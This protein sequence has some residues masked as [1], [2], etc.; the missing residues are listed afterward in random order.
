MITL[1]LRKTRLYFY[2]ATISLTLLGRVLEG[3][4][5]EAES[6]RGWKLNIPGSSAL[7]LL[8]FA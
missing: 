5:H 4:F 8:G 1:F 3:K 2:H 6:V 7:C